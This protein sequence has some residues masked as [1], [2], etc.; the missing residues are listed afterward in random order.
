MR[1]SMIEEDLDTYNNRETMGTIPYN[2]SE[3]LPDNHNIMQLFLPNKTPE[4]V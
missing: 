4:L 3:I 1:L 2:Y